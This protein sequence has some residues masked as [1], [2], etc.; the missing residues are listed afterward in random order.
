MSKIAVD[1]MGGDNAPDEIIKGCM[2][3]IKEIDS[4]LVL[5]GKESIIKEKLSAYTY[6]EAKVEIVN[7]D[8]VIEMGRKIGQKREIFYTVA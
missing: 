4:T 1:I 8:E 6:D 7:A 2:M 5:V 3:A